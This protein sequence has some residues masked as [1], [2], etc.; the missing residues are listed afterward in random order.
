M[1]IFAPIS[2]NFS[3]VATTNK[4]IVKDNFVVNTE[5]SA[6]VKITCIS[7]EFKNRF[8]NKIEDPST[9][10][11][12]CGRNL[13]K[14]SVDEPILS[15]LGGQ[16]KAE[17]TLTEIYAMMKNQAE[18]N[19]GII[20]TNEC[21]NIFYARDINNTLCVVTIRWFSD[22]WDVGASSVEDPDKWLADDRVFSRNSS[23]A[24]N[25]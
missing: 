10:S 21:A 19:A 15:E 24:K 9:H 25:A 17:T 16:E 20:L 22:G 14:D 6:V 3:V 11:I 2:S 13:I 5:D 1:I 23:E 4:F 8:I 18:G 12:I 7:E